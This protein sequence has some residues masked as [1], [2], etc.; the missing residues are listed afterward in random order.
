MPSTPALSVI[1]PV[2]NEA[3][4]IG[5]TLDTIIRRA[6]ACVIVVVD[7][8]STDGTCAIVDKY[9]GVRLLQAGHRGRAAQMNAGAAVARGKHLLFLHADTHPPRGF[10]QLIVKHLNQPG[11]AAGGFGLTFDARHWLL[12]L[13]ARVT[14]MNF[15]WL[16]FGD[17]GMFMRKSMFEAVGGYADM[18]ILED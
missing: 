14:Q 15:P 7:G 3:H 8:G 11:V 10:D 2:L 12:D 13:I 17:H 6:S 5:F 16:T 18:P 4:C 9:P 1:I